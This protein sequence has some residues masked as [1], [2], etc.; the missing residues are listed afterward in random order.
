[1]SIVFVPL[2]LFAAALVVAGSA[3]WILALVDCVRRDFPG[4]NDRLM[5]VV[6]ILLGHIVGALIYWVV[7]RPRGDMVAA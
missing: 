4:A 1:M 3:L 5:W 2:W 6:I 7:G